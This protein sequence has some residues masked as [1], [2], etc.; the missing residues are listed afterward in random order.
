MLASPSKSRATAIHPI[1]YAK[2]NESQT[3]SCDSRGQPLSACVWEV[4]TH[5]RPET[6]V[7][8]KQ[9]TENDN[10][11][12]VDGVLYAGDGLEAG[13]CS[14]EI[15]SVT[16]EDAGLWSCTLLAKSGTIFAGT[17]T[18]EMGKQKDVPG[19]YR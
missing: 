10:Q 1:I 16:D 11:T 3:I 5:D 13:R 4:N 14:L 12:S 8:Y 15:E 17:V 7:I 9:D 18:V 6:I 2:A 19:V